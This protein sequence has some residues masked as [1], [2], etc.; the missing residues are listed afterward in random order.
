VTAP[1]ITTLLDAVN[2]CLSAIGEQPINSLAGNV[3]PEASMALQ[4]LNEIHLE[5]ASRGWHH[6][7]D[8]DVEFV[9]DVN[10]KIALPAN[11]VRFAVDR[12]W[13]SWADVT[14]R[15]DAGV[16]RLYDKVGQTFVIGQTLK[17]EVVYLFDFEAT[18][19]SYRRYVV[20]RAARIFHDR[21]VGS[22]AHHAYTEADERRALQF[23]KQHEDTVDERSIFD[24]YAA[25]RV[26]DRRYPNTRGGWGI[27]W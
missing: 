4:I 21:T 25:Y 16:V 2:R 11:V 6:N 24:S 22:Q 3:P 1:T 5:A 14:T 20:T 12:S 27:N 26:I 18:P 15:D 19:E 9:P 10:G 17:A 13:S 7:T 8:R 23:L